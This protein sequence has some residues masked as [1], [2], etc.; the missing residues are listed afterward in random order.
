[1]YNYCNHTVGQNQIKVVFDSEYA[2]V[3]HLEGYDRISQYYF[4]PGDYNTDSNEEDNSS[5]D[6]EDGK[7]ED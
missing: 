3:V 4:H 2:W 7:V 1:M 6:S 5:G